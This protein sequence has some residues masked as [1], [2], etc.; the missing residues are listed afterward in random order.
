MGLTI[1]IHLVGFFWGG[2]VANGVGGKEPAKCTTEVGAEC[3]IRAGV[4]IDDCNC[5]EVEAAVDA[6][7]NTGAAV[8]ADPNSAV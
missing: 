5:C 7:A 6:K 3:D 8:N 4:R 2:G 1:S